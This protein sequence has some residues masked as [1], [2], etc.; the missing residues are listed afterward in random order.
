MAR[1]DD[2]VEREFHNLRHE[3]AVEL[4]PETAL[5]RTRAPWNSMETSE[6]KAH[7]DAVEA[8]AQAQDERTSAAEVRELQ[9][10]V[11]RQHGGAGDSPMGGRDD[12]SPGGGR[13]TQQHSRAG[14][15]PVGGR[16]NGRSTQQHDG[17][18]DAPHEAPGRPNGGRS[19]QQHGGAGDSPNGG[20]STQQ[21][22]GA[23]D[24]PMGGRDTQRGA[25]DR[26]M[27]YPQST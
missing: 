24:S 6:I 5:I 19:T 25:G 7:V 3:A 1:F 22:G 4:L 8:K 12:G 18:G 16:P 17:A 21:H 13:N 9:E 15:G 20:H 23:G 27:N 14:D 2:L 11:R 26:T 10:R